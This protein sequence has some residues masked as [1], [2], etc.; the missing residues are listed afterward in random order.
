MGGVLDEADRPN[1]TLYE[2]WECLHYDEDIPVTF[3][4]LYQAYLDG[5]LVPYR[6]G[7]NNYY[8]LQ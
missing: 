5:D 1:K 2:L 4:R 7:N 6:L 3:R 8:S